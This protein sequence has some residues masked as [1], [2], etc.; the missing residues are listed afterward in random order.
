[1]LYKHDQFFLL[2]QF[3]CI[4]SIPQNVM[5]THL[6]KNVLSNNL[7]IQNIDSGNELIVDNKRLNKKTATSGSRKR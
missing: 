6:I 3:T 2:D 5:K 1:M 4:S 7:S